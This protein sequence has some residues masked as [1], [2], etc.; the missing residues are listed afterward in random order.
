MKL[1]L[2]GLSFGFGISLPTLFEAYR[3]TTNPR[4][5]LPL[6]VETLA[7]RI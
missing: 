7:I 6:Y 5:Q 2:W 4:N 1:F 3:A